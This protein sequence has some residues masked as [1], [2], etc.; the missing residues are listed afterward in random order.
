MEGSV[1]CRQL[2]ASQLYA[3]QQ[4][5]QRGSLDIRMHRIISKSVEFKLLQRRADE[6]QD[7]LYLVWQSL[8]RD[9]QGLHD[10]QGFRDGQGLHDSKLVTL[11]LLDPWKLFFIM[12]GT[13]DQMLKCP[14]SRT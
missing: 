2:Y 4:Q 7:D 8:L 3:T 11:P 1:R 12:A 10:G 9:G 5:E 13:Y 14:L 6:G